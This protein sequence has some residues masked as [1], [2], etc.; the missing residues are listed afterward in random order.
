MKEIYIITGK[1][2]YSKDKSISFKFMFDSKIDFN[3]ISKYPKYGMIRKTEDGQW[4]ITA[5]KNGEIVFSGGFRI[6]QEDIFYDTVYLMKE[7]EYYEFIDKYKDVINYKVFHS[8]ISL[9]QS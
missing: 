4:F 2:I 3:E 5:G 6:I 1:E 7:D 8:K 9:Y